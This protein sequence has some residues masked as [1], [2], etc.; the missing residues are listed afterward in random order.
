MRLKTY[1]LLFSELL[2]ESTIT[3]YQ[4]SVF[5]NLTGAGFDRIY[6]LK[7]LAVDRPWSDLG[8]NDYASIVIGFVQSSSNNRTLT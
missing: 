5:Q 2:Q 4:M 3:M 8:E 1:I 7:N 6:S